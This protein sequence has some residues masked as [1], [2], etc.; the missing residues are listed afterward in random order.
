MP[1]GSPNPPPG[2]FEPFVT[3]TTSPPPFTAVARSTL[4][5]A[6]ALGLAAAILVGAP[7]A[8]GRARHTQAAEPTPTPLPPCAV[9]ATRH[10][11]PQVARIGERVDVTLSLKASCPIERLPLHLVVVV[12]ASAD[13]DTADGRGALRSLQRSLAA[14]RPAERTALRVGVVSANAQAIATCPLRAGTADARRCIGR[15]RPRGAARLA[16]GIERAQRL[17]ADARAMA[18]LPHDTIREVVAVVARLPR[19]TAPCHDVPV[20]A[21]RVRDA[22][23]TLVALCV[24]DDCDTACLRGS[25]ASPRHVVAWRSPG[26]LQ[27]AMDDLLTPPAPFGTAPLIVRDL[28]VTETLPASVTLVADRVQPDPSSTRQA[29]TTLVWRHT[30]VPKDGVT[31]TYPVVIAASGALTV[32]ARSFGSFVDPRRGVATF[33]PPLG[34]I[35]VTP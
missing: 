15:I 2:V 14:Y 26:A 30:H 13:I 35:A 7:P 17:L 27:A 29:P 9:T 21:G 24:G 28:T 23:A 1:V 16:S 3:T 22:G 20:A 11:A 19:G 4:A 25:A 8:S 18:A 34:H 31:L 5:A 6:T 33:A 32:P 10:I 12:D